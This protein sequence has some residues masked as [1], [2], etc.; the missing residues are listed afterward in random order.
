MPPFSE[1]QPDSGPQSAPDAEGLAGCEIVLGVGGGVAC[2]K[3]AMLASLL[4]K[5]GAGVSVI[6][7]ASATKFVGEATFAAL[8]GRPVATRLFDSGRYPLGGHIELAA[9]ADLVVIAP[10]TA[11]VL[12]KAAHGLADDLLSTL[13][14]AAECPVVLAPAM[15]TAMWAKPS[16]QRNVRQLVDDGL[17]IIDPESGWL[18]CRREGAG[19]MAEPAAI[20]TILA[21]VVKGGALPRPSMR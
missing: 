3:A 6:L 12:A 8:T 4:V 5:Q 1:H 2:Y 17:G 11:D 7:T 15:N 20:A 9:A 13:L 10:A 14:L 19:R 16:V 21:G 18:A